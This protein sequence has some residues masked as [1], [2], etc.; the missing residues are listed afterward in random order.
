MRIA[1]IT[2]EFSGLPGSGGIG[3]Y[4]RQ[5]AQ[6]LVEGGQT[7]EVFTAGQPGDLAAMPGVRFHHLGSPQPPEF[8]VMA[9]H[10]VEARQAAAPFDLIECGELKAEGHLAA[11]AIPSAAF[12]VRLHS[13]SIILDRYLDFAPGWRSRCVSVY[14][15]LRSLLGAWR[16]GLPLQPI[17]LEPFS[18]TWIPS[19]D[20]EE[21]NAAA[22]ADLVI[23]MNQELREFALRHWWIKPEAIA[24]VPNPLQLDITAPVQSPV[25][26]PP[27]LGF[28]GRLE[29]RKGIVELAKSLVQVLPEFPG[30]QVEIAGRSMP[31]CVSGSDAGEIAREILKPFADRVKFVGPV[32]PEDVPSWL[33]RMH[34]CVFPS[35]WETF[36]YV[37]LE[38]AAAGK[39]IVATDTGVISTILNEGKAGEIVPPG[40]IKALTTALRAMMSDPE[41]RQ[42]CG[43]AARARV[44][45]K[46]HHEK[47]TQ[48]ILSAYQCALLRRDQRLAART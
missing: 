38:A 29:P 7:V 18:F 44:M 30:W 40:N 20:A 26:E 23:V 17:R 16:R 35:L 33:A 21:R 19:R 14:W 6:C 31:S 42:R 46:Y 5:L 48:Q 13:P 8:A 4:F 27:T 15:Q 36:S 22:G 47:V 1:L 43:A 34:L 25:G 39:A 3:S 32:K 45:E 9:K 10:A 12:V 2:S 11:M 24:E 41:R 28:L 37:V